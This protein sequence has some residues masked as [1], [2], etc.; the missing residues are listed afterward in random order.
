MTHKA[1]LLRGVWGF[2]LVLLDPFP[3]EVFF[4]VTFS[5]ADSEVYNLRH[6]I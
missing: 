2:I 5:E 3:Q 4:I 1:G 6:T